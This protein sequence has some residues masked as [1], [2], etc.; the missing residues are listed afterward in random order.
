[1]IFETSLHTPCAFVHVHTLIHSEPQHFQTVA[2]KLPAYC[3]AHSHSFLWTVA[4]ASILGVPSLATVNLYSL[5][6]PFE[7]DLNSKR[8]HIQR[9]IAHNIH[10]G[11]F[12]HQSPM[13]NTLKHAHTTIITS[14]RNLR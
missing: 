1:M 7:R 3:R 6:V 12:T 13:Q 9:H 14:T 4:H 8:R 11:S 10:K 5:R 2:Q